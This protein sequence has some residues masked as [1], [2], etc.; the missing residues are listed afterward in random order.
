MIEMPIGLLTP[1]T[2]F[3]DPP[4]SAIGRPIEATVVSN[5]LTARGSEMVIYSEGPGS[6]G[7]TWHLYRPTMT[8]QVFED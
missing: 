6:R 2:R 3:I 4:A 7:N 8:V 5:T 1:G